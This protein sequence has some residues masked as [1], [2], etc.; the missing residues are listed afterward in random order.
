[1]KAQLLLCLLALALHSS[2]QQA[3]FSHFNA[4]SGIHTNE[5][6]K[7]LIF[8]IG[9]PIN[10]YV[11]SEF[12]QAPPGGIL[13]QGM[14]HSETTTLEEG[15]AEIQ[16]RVFLDSNS[17]GIKDP[18]EAYIS[19]GSVQVDGQ[20]M[21]AIISEEGL[22]YIASPGVYSFIY[23]N[24]NALFNN[25]N[26]TS[27]E[28]E[29]EDGDR[30]KKV[31]FGI[32]PE[33]VIERAIIYIS[34]GRLRCFRTVDYSMCIR[35]TGTQKLIKTVYVE[36]D[37]RLMP[38]TF[39]QEPDVRVTDNIVGWDICLE[40]GRNNT[41]QYS[42]QAPEV[43][44][45]E[46]IGVSYFSSAWVDL[47]NNGR[48]EDR[49][50]FESVQE[51]VCAY[52]P[53]D[54]LVTPDRP[55][56]LALL[57]EPLIYTI[58]FQNTGN[59]IADDV[60]V[61]D[62]MD[63][64][65]D[66]STFYVLDNSHPDQLQ[67]LIDPDNEHIVNF[68]FKNIFLPDSI[69]NE[70]GS[71]GF[72]TYSI[73]PVEGLPADTEITNTAHIFFDFNPAIVTNTT[74]S[75]LVDSFPPP[76]E[77]VRTTVS[78]VICQGESHE[79]YTEA[80]EYEDIFPLAV[81]VDSIRLL[82][83]FTLEATNNIIDKVICDGDS[84]D[85]Y[86]E[87]G[88][89]RDTIPVG[90][91]SNIQQLN[92]EVIDRHETYEQISLCAG[93][94]YMG[95]SGAGVIV[96]NLRSVNNCDSIHVIELIT[97]GETVMISQQICEGDSFE[98]YRE[99]GIYEDVFVT[100]AGCD[101]IRTLDLQVADELLI[102]I[103]QTICAGEQYEGYMES[104]NYEDRFLTSA[105]C[106][107]VRMLDLIVLPEATQSEE[108][109]ICEGDSF[110]GYSITGRYSIVGL[111]SSAG[112]DST[113]VIDL[114]VL[115]SLQEVVELELCEGE[116]YEGYD[117][118]GEYSDI[119]SSINDCDSTRTLILTVLP[120]LS[121]EL[122]VEICQGEN[123]EGLTESGTYEDIFQANNGCDSIRNLNLTVLS[124]ATTMIDINICE[125]DSFEGYSTSGTFEDVFVGINGC[126]SIRT[127]SLSVAQS[128]EE[129][130][131]VEICDGETYEGYTTTGTYSDSFTT[132]SG[133]DSTRILELT[134]LPNLSTGLDVQICEGESYEGYSTSGVFEDS[135]TSSNGCDSIRTLSLSVAQSI[136][137][138][139][140]VEI[141]SGDSYEGYTVT[142]T[143]RDMFS[144]SE[145]CDS[146]RVLDLQVVESLESFEEV[147]FCIGETYEGFDRPG[148]Y[149]ITHTSTGG[150]DSIRHIE[151][152]AIDRSDPI[153][154]FNFDDQPKDF[155]DTEF[156]SV[157]P[158]PSMD[159]INIV[160]DKA[161]R[162]PSEI[163]ILS[164]ERKLLHTQVITTQ[165]T[166]VD[167]SAYAAG[168]YILVLKNGNNIYVQRIIK[169]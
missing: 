169:S 1:M 131:S 4:H 127:L 121:S 161:S 154:A 59:D 99:S 116:S 71:H 10:T 147:L 46:D 105:G 168:V 128:I 142:G 52:D 141:C 26:T 137:V 53:N 136:E 156:L 146:I 101:S 89:Y 114:T 41:F 129:N 58:R 152:I 158:N 29:I 160:V 8:A 79:G 108:V 159:L 113:R 69:S 139:T 20:E 119:F 124:T 123:Y 92:L 49:V 11:D 134:V 38:Y 51:L 102:E 65:L 17:D 96:E 151:L 28:V 61:A 31:D 15:L 135:F 115:E 87:A 68:Q 76:L 36:L 32:A 112:C 148:S 5:D 133:C 107:S 43:M 19:E 60:V 83:L 162:L 149:S 47:Q 165:T 23:F 118:S 13:Q 90:P 14:M 73:S 106:D 95:Y 7:R 62:T 138:N 6:G 94:S 144:N 64:N 50:G 56:S 132:A 104:G 77:D 86:T 48:V 57:D 167:L 100:A 117:T 157:F 93:D 78:R 66:M 2:A 63:T 24:E 88:I 3:G 126:D 12:R 163:E 39:N 22:R 91:C 75:T 30:Y 97:S 9:E 82:K 72:I 45:P 37:S 120:H 110:E 84:Y 166:A 109:E 70:P 122:D 145:G 111:T 81:G 44:V 54:K 27:V 164:I 67:V 25:T 16:V 153:C 21:Y 85:G 42:V 125:G 55:D 103:N 140:A 35:D 143:Y 34:G 40:P 98:G 18:D 150:C 33:D 130:T 155:Q 74:S 80:G